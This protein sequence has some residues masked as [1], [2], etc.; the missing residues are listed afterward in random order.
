MT[1][2]FKVI[3][4]ARLASTRLPGKPLL[5]IG[6]KPLI[7]HV[8]EAA[9]QS[10]AV[11]VIVATDSI[12]IHHRVEAFGG[13]VQMTSVAHNSGT[14]RLIELVDK[15]HEPDESIIVNLQ[16]DEFNMPSE[17]VDQVAEA[18]MNH[19]RIG[20][21]TL[22]DPITDMADFQNPNIVKVVFDR[23]QIALDFSRKSIAWYGDGPEPAA[24]V[25]GYRHIGIYAYRVWFLRLYATLLPCDREKTER[26]EQLRVLD[27]G[28][29]IHVDIANTRPGIGIDTPEDLQKAQQ[30]AD[31][32]I[33]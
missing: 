13:S 7:Q 25:Y 32:Q 28:Y 17:L 16:G 8:Y 21:A 15:L 6:N 18:L 31:A 27:R 11:S 22:C 19:D 5:E 20:M 23:N 12:D 9:K 2:S 26:L 14:E 3:I 29:D 33:L 10:A 24:G 4:P 30:L 1:E